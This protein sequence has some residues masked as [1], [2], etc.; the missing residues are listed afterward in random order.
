MGVDDT[1]G[2]QKDFWTPVVGKGFALKGS[3][4][5]GLPAGS[6]GALTIS[7]VAPHGVGSNSPRCVVLFAPAHNIPLKVSDGRAAPPA[8]SGAREGSKEVVGVP[9]HFTTKPRSD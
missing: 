1:L 3:A 5:A 9:F 8:T 6:F 7:L 2:T 4:E